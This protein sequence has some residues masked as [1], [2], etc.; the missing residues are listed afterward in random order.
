M[1]KL[2]QNRKATSLTALWRM[3]K[4]ADLPW[5]HYIL[6]LLI[7]LALG[8]IT[9]YMPQLE[10]QIAA[11]EIFNA[12][13]IRRYIILAIVMA[14]AQ[15][16]GAYTIWVDVT[17]V[18]R[19]QKYSWRRFIRLPLPVFERIQPSTLISRV[20][21]DSTMVATII[22]YVLSAITTL[23]TGGYMIIN[24]FLQNAKLAAM[25]VPLII[26]NAA[27]FVF[28]R[29][30]VYDIGY[31]V[32]DT[33]AKLTGFIAERV[34]AMRQI[35]AANMQDKEYKKGQDHSQARFKAEMRNVKYETA[36]LA[37]M[38]I[39]QALLTG[40]VLIGGAVMVQ[41]GSLTMSELIA[42]Y[43]YM[44]M[45]PN[46]L[47][48]MMMT[49][50]QLRSLRGSIEVVT[51]VNNLP[52]E[53]ME[54]EQAMPETVR[55]LRFADVSFTYPGT[56]EPVLDGL[57]L[58]IP[59]GKTTAI[60]GPSGA[61]KT[62]L[63]KLLERFYKPDQGTIY[64]GDEPVESFHLDDWRRRF[65]Y[66]IQN[67]PLLNGTIRDN[68]L[69]GTDRNLSDEELLQ[70]CDR[71]Q[72]RDFIDS[73]PDGLDTWVGPEGSLISGGQRQ[74]IAIARALA[75]EPDILLL[76]EA[77]A[78]LDAKNSTE[79]TAALDELMRDKTVIVVAHQMKTIRNADKVVVLDEG[80]LDAEGTHDELVDSQ[81][82]YHRYCLLQQTE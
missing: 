10:A 46:I 23:W 58:V 22:S 55:P 3:L 69:Y 70:L 30:Y 18:K 43:M 28:A 27:F 79:V 61:G 17:V 80:H 81:N 5:I 8:T 56:D 75:A 63:L 39:T 2:K 21:E 11:G 12:D 68:I 45:L 44:F 73:L 16:V 34:T 15:L 52:S 57:N 66:V 40:I 71:A 76:D 24:M 54:R 59:A 33:M 20:T 82:Y 36:V 29:V 26:L 1:K 42:F 41:N 19:L 31:S 74:R 4:D 51:E 13:L 49:L 62:T 35:K 6:S 53:V 25:T 14:C 67:S 9:G 7:S 77:T 38:Q 47:Q 50:L 64:Y 48:Q 78:S 60:V 65:G 37:V 32:Q 72:I